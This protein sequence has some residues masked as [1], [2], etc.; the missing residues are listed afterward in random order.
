MKALVTTVSAA[1]LLFLATGSAPADPPPTDAP[2]TG[3]IHAN[4]GFERGTTGWTAGPRIVVLGDAARPAHSGRAYATFAGL[5]VTRSDLLRTTVTVPAECDLTVRFRVRTTTT[6]SSRSDYLNVGLA[7]T[8]IPPKTRFSLAFD[9]GA[10]WREY[11]M[12]SGTATVERTATVSFLASET[13]GNGV[14]TFDLDDVTFTL[15]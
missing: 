14:T 8:G 4:P 12:S 3:Q 2:C 15:S 6:E 1:A 13:A 10:Q 11:A 9:G 7:V 5:D